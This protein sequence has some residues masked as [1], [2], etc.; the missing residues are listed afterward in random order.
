MLTQVMADKILRHSAPQ[1]VMYTAAYTA[2]GSHRG[3]I[4]ASVIRLE[5]EGEEKAEKKHE[6]T[7]VYGTKRFRAVQRLYR[8][9]IGAQ[10]LHSD[11]RS[12][13]GTASRFATCK[14]GTTSDEKPA[15]P[16]ATLSS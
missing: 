9:G 7:G 8:R 2:N 12:P 1:N 16:W 6:R 4:A 13:L 3:A 14:I 10:G 15:S 5:Y 11:P